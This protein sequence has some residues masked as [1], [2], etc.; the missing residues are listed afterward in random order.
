ML[1]AL[2]S[3]PGQQVLGAL[4]LFRICY[5]LIPFIIALALLGGYEIRRRLKALRPVLD[6]RDEA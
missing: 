1:L 2:S 3:L 5:Y 6:S 4:L